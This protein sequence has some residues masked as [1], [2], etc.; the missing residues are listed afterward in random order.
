MLHELIYLFQILDSTTLH[1]R[2]HLRPPPRH[3][4]SMPIASLMHPSSFSISHTLAHLCLPAT[5]N[6]SR[7][8]SHTKPSD[9]KI[10]VPRH[11]QRRVREERRLGPI[12][13]PLTLIANSLVVPVPPAHA[14]PTRRAFPTLTARS[15]RRA[16]SARERAVFPFSLPPAPMHAGEISFGISCGAGCVCLQRARRLPEQQQQQQQKDFRF[17]WTAPDDGARTSPSPSV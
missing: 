6:P 5:G 3:A 9:T 13:F 8:A 12:P 17:I 15:H 14:A 16:A 11:V 4:R 7:K 2:H 10:K 1:H